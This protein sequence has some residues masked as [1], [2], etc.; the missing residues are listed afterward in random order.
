[1]LGKKNVRGIGRENVRGNFPIPMQDYKSVCVA[2]MIWLTYRHAHKQ[3]V[4]DR[5]CY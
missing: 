1:M 4:L 2:V 3:T 5:P